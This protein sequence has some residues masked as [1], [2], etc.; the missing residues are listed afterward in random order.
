MKR[1]LI[2]FISFIVIANIFSKDI[3]RRGFKFW[4]PD[5]IV[6]EST[7]YTDKERWIADYN[8]DKD[9]LVLHLPMTKYSD[10]GY[11][12]LNVA[13]SL[14]YLLENGFGNYFQDFVLTE[15]KNIRENSSY[16][17]KFEG[18]ATYYRDSTVGDESKPVFASVS[19]IFMQNDDGE[20]N[21]FGILVISDSAN[22]KYKKLA[23]KILKSLK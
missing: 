11:V 20:V 23:S 8:K 17:M 16:K 18:K 2:W 9:F 3:D 19:G 14:V 1:A 6:S 4:L 22:K 12:S 7:D 13:Q 21:T 10:D 5:D 15:V